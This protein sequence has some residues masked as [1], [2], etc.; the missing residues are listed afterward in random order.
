VLKARNGLR[1]WENWDV[2]ADMSVA[3]LV[4]SVRGSGDYRFHVFCQ[5]L[6][7]LQ[8]TSAHMYAR[9]HGVLIEGDI[10]ILVSRDSSDVWAQPGMFHLEYAAGAPPDMYCEDGQ[11]WGFPTYRWDVVRARDY[12]WWRGRLR[13]ASRYF[14]LYR[15]DH[16]VGF[17]RIWTIDVNAPNGRTGWFDP[18]DEARWGEHGR[19][20]LQMMLNS[21]GMLPLAE[22]LGTIPPIC[23]STL[24]DMGICGL[25]VQRWEKRWDTDRRFIEPRDYDPISVATLSTHDC[26]IAADWWATADESD[27]AEIWTM[28]GREGPAPTTPG[29]ADELDFLTWFAGAGSL[30]VVLALQDLIHPFGL[31]ENPLS[32]HRINLPGTVGPHNWSWRCP[33]SIREMAGNA[34]LIAG[35]K[36]IADRIRARQAPEVCDRI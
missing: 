7:D 20:I 26:D 12:D 9:E 5:W 24:R 2:P 15:I 1:S 11:H 34:E 33:V 19:S 3:D 29:G 32:D 21:T 31:L 8:F 28:M 18:S 23:R 6:M 22:D 17:F 27:R 14:D 4:S 16:V 35:W 36:S 13:Q 30:F 25:K 10:P